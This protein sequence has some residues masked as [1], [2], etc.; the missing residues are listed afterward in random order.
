MSISVSPLIRIHN[1]TKFSVELQISRPE[2]MEDE[3][4]SVLLK[5]GDTFDDSM[6][7]FDAINF[8]GGFRK[9]VMS[10]NVGMCC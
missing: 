6:A 7:S 3:F 1:E 5:A 10:L 4:A 8:S 9:A 2:P